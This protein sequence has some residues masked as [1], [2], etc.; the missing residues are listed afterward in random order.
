M[1]VYRVI[2]FRLGTSW[3]VW[4]TF[5]DWVCGDWF[6]KEKD[7]PKKYSKAQSKRANTNQEEIGSAQAVN[8]S[9]HFQTSNYSDHSI[10]I[11]ESVWEISSRGMI[12]LEQICIRS[13]W[14]EA[15]WVTCIQRFGPCVMIELLPSLWSHVTSLLKQ[16]SS[17]SSKDNILGSERV[18]QV[19]QFWD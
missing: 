4:E 11:D 19:P 3:L 6:E 8:K 15:F 10:N 1:N 13:S 18:S 12:I 7:R 14:D 16:K 2:C 5:S 9:Q 17:D